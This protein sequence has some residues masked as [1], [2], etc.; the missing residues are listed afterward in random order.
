MIRLSEK[1]RAALNTL[2]SGG[3]LPATK[4]EEEYVKNLVDNLNDGQRKAFDTVMS[5]RNVFIT[6]SGGVGKSFLLKA[7]IAQMKVDRKEV[8][9]LASTGQACSN[10]I[11]SGIKA[12]TIHSYFKNGTGIWYHKGKRKDFI[13]N[14][15]TLINKKIDVIIIDEISMCRVDVFD[16]ICNSVKKAGCQLIIVGDFYQLPPVVEDEVAVELSDIYKEPSPDWFAFDGE[17]WKSMDF[18]MC[19]LSEV[20]RQKNERDQMILNDL[21]VGKF[22]TWDSNLYLIDNERNLDEYIYLMPTKKQVQFINEQELAK[23]DVGEY[24][25]EFYGNKD[26][27]FVSEAN[28]IDGNR[29][30]DYIDEEDRYLYL[31]VGAKVMITVNQ[32]S[33]Y[34]KANDWF[35]IHGYDRNF[36]G[37]YNGMVCIVERIMPSLKADEEELDWNDVSVMVRPI[38]SPCVHIE[39]KKKVF[40]ATEINRKTLKR[41]DVGRYEQFPLRLAYAIT[42]HKAQG[43][44]YSQGVIIDPHCGWAPGLLYVALSR[45]TE[46]KNVILTEWIQPEFFIANQRVT[47]F[48]EEMRKAA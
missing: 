12:L 13:N 23:I 9:T 15:R 8:I 35:E 38:N 30:D 17:N 29:T 18:V 27:V 19:E 48:Y 40:N 44:T 41:N 26:G 33:D 21:R 6:G 32:P 36:N 46:L 42:I 43:S 4:K 2:R 14:S 39:F 34:N 28:V 47:K 45:A 11:T 20:V 24:D 3:K 7:I 1:E 10:L 5:G 16:S 31:K 37:F 25:A 22:N